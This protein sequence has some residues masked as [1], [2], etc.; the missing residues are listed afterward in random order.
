MSVLGDP[1][2]MVVGFDQVFQLLGWPGDVS[3]TE[4]KVVIFGYFVHMMVPPLLTCPF[5]HLEGGAVGL[6]MG[7]VDTRVQGQVT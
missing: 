2:P 5:V 6:N 1:V 7:K 4:G 3:V